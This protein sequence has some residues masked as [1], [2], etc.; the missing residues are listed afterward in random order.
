MD[1]STMIAVFDVQCYLH[2]YAAV[3]GVRIGD[4]HKGYVLKG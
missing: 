4:T 1:K 3:V 2:M